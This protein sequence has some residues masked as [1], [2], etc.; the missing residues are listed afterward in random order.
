[1]S[2]ELQSLLDACVDAVIIIDH[3]G[4]IETCNQSACRLFGYAQAEL[5]GHNVS[6]LMPQPDRDQHDGYMHRHLATREARIIGIGREVIGR[7]RDGSE[8]PVALAIGRIGSRE[9]PRFVGFMHDLTGRRAQEQQ[10]LTA[11][12]A[13]REARERL[14]HVARLSTLGEMTTGLAHEINQPLT[15]ITMYAQ[16]AE[17]FLAATPPVLDEVAAA[18]LQISTQSLRA[19][20]IIRRLRD[21]VR[22]RARHEELLDPNSVVR[23]LAVLA[24]TDARMHAVQISNQLGAGLPQVL[25]DTVQLQQVLLNLVRNAIDA[26]TQTPGCERHIILRTARCAAGVE[27][28]VSDPGP[29]LDP[30]IRD[31]LFEAFATTKPEGTG[32]GLAISRSIVESHGGHLGW[33]ANLPQGSC[34]YFTLP[35][36]S[37]AEP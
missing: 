4:S 27:I 7:R 10:R 22:N 8:I 12:E 3:H 11:Q 18:L 2:D 29:G 20:E 16:A 9:P 1:M 21:L 28:S 32:L 33:R 15:A 36:V 35:A 31:R 6:M 34:F 30:A 19:G 5:L 17:R 13:V 25:G 23:E 14:T 24:E 26:V 37:G